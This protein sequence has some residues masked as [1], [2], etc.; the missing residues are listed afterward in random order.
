MVIV[1]CICIVGKESLLKTDA[2]KFAFYHY[3]EVRY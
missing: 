3:K 1:G 2:M